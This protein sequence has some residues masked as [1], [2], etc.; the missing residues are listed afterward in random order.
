MKWRLCS[1]RIFVKWPMLHFQNS[2]VCAVFFAGI[3]W[4]KFPL[5]FLATGSNYLDTV[6]HNKSLVLSLVRQVVTPKQVAPSSEAVAISRVH[7]LDDEKQRV[8]RAMFVN[9]CRII[10]IIN[11]ITGSV[12]QWLSHTEPETSFRRQ[13]AGILEASG[14]YWRGF[15]QFWHSANETGHVWRWK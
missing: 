4:I 11:I 3:C 8:C 7:K 9:C 10:P 2:V 15:W 12:R 1:L 13:L 14:G 5:L 6:L